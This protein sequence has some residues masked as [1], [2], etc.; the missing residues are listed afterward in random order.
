MDISAMDRERVQELFDA[1]VVGPDG[2][3]VGTVEQIFA[4][5][6]TGAP[7]FITV[8]SGDRESYIP[9]SGAEF[10]GDAVTIPFSKDVVD[11]APTASE[12]EE[13]SLEQETSLYRYYGIRPPRRSSAEPAKPDEQPVGEGVPPSHAQ[14]GELEDIYRKPEVPEGAE[15]AEP[16]DG[17]QPEESDEASA[18]V[19]PESDGRPVEVPDPLAVPII[20][21]DEVD[22]PDET[23]ASRPVVSADRGDTALPDGAKLRKYVITEMVTVQIPVRR[24]VVCYED[25][26]G[27]LHELETIAP[28]ASSQSEPEQTVPEPAASAEPEAPE[29]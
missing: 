13:L 18:A 28:P 14:P 19:P 24:E 15:S 21:P 1:G 10:E 16:V 7:T 17:P 25:A 29:S 2:Q 8:R 20:E 26:D 9:V 12:A 4:D 22:K 23:E 11:A 5:D 6:A 27:V 3:Q